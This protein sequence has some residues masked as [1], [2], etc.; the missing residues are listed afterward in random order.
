MEDIPLVVKAQEEASLWV[1]VNNTSVLE[2]GRMSRGVEHEWRW[3]RP[4]PGFL[5]CNVSSSWINAASPR[6][7]GRILRDHSGQVYGGLKSIRL[8]IGCFPLCEI[9]G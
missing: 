9:F 2:L 8:N 3:K 4:R 6:V 7:G 5:K 1:E